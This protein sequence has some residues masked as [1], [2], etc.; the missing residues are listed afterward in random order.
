MLQLG[1]FVLAGLQPG[2]AKPAILRADDPQGPVLA[3]RLK[4]NS[5]T[6][7]ALLGEPHAGQ[8]LS[9]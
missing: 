5:A 1:Q 3:G 7:Y 4:R 2:K 6:A 9:H 8:A